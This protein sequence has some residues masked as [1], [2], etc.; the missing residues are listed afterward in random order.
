MACAT[1]AWATFSGETMMI[2]SRGTE[3]FFDSSTDDAKSRAR[4]AVDL[5]V[6]RIV[7]EIAA[8]LFHL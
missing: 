2:Q 4:A 1:S 7:R 3:T 8:L 5:Y 6:R